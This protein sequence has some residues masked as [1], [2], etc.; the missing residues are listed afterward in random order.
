M[1]WVFCLQWGRHLDVEMVQGLGTWERKSQRDD[2]E[3]CFHHIRA[4]DKNMGLSR[5]RGHRF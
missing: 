3:L 5:L 4:A 1:T 2:K